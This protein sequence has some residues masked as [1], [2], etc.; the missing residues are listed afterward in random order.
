MTSLRRLVVF[1][2]FLLW[3][4]GFLFYT[5]V[6]VP[7]GTDVLG[8]SL[9]QG[10]ITRRVTD[11]LNLFGAAW[12]AAFAWD[13]LACRDPARRRRL[14][15]WLGWAGCV[16]LLGVLAWLHGELDSL[17]DLEAEK[18][19]D[20]PTF[21]AIHIVYLWVST[22]HWALALGLAWLTLRAWRA[23][24]GVPSSRVPSSKSEP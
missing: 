3:Q 8:S 2:A 6:V 16:A 5:A 1:Q 4:G 17:I 13:L 7:I 10:L 11:R 15:R 23:E 20:R 22:I 9:V 18:L 21:K 12:A 19:R 24:D 14:A